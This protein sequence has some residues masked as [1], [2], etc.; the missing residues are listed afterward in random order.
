MDFRDLYKRDGS[1]LYV[2]ATGSVEAD[3]FRLVHEVMMG[4]DCCVPAARAA[5][6]DADFLADYF[7]PYENLRACDLAIIMDVES[8]DFR[9]LQDYLT[10][11][12][13][14]ADDSLERDG[15]QIAE[16]IYESL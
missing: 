8:S 1:R 5:L 13:D 4:A 6:R 3:V 12:V 7:Y 16:E 9:A 14:L 11:V 15:A 2:K 10:Q